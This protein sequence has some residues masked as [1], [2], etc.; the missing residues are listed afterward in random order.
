MQSPTET[1]AG[2]MNATLE[3][4]AQLKLIPNADEFVCS[5]CEDFFMTNQGVVLMGC[6]HNFCQPCLTRAILSSKTKDVRCPMRIVDCHKNLQFCEI[7]A[8]LPKDAFEKFIME[9]PFTNTDS[10][11]M[12][13]STTMPNL[14][15]LEQ[16]HDYVENRDIFKCT[17]CLTDIMPGDGIM[18]KNCL[19]EHCKTCLALTI[20][21]SEEMEVPCPYV[22][23]NGTHCEG[24]LQDRELRSLITDIVYS[25]HLEKSL[26]RAEAITKNSFHCKTPDCPSWAEIGELVTSFICPICMKTNCVKC[27][28]IHEGRTCLEYFYENNEGARKNRDDTMTANQLQQLIVEKKAQACP[29]CGV[30]IEKTVGCNHMTCSRCKR[31]FQWHGLA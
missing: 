3:Y 26:K 7:E 19:H 11:D 12:M 20:E 15:D 8:L 17:I 27:E 25:A 13:D 2:D 14:M 31:Q 10:D 23:D 18:L 1:F 9:T 21:M 28:V 29:G 4:V 30:V 5:I 6:H 22:A 24:T 16:N